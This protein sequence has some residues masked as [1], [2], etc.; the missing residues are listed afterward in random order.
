MNPIRWKREH[1]VALLIGAALGFLFGFGYA[2]RDLRT[3]CWIQYGCVEENLF[4]WLT[5]LAAGVGGALVGA[6][7]IYAA[8]LTRK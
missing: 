7:I 2:L 5:I 6:T 1:H 3:P 8:I 4:Y